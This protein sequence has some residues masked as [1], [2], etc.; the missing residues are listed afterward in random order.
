MVG[1]AVAGAHVD[2]AAPATG[3][4]APGPPSRRDALVEDEVLHCG[5]FADVA[6]RFPTTSGD[7][8]EVYGQRALFALLSP[9]LR[10]QLFPAAEAACRSGGRHEVQLDP[11][12]TARGFQ[13]VVRYVYRLPPQFTRPAL[14]EIL[15]AAHVLDVRELEE[16]AFTWGLAGLAERVQTDVAVDEACKCVQGA[17]D[18]NDCVAGG[19]YGDEVTDALWCLEQLCTLEPRAKRVTAWR[20]ALIK[21]YT[22]KQILASEAFFGLSPVTLEELLKEDS[23]HSDPGT[24]WVT[25]VH[26]AWACAQRHPPVEQPAMPEGAKPPKLFGRNT[27][28]AAILAPAV[29]PGQLVAWQ[30]QLLPVVE[31]MRFAQMAAA[32]FAKHVESLDPMLPELRQA[33]FS[34]RRRAATAQHQASVPPQAS[35]QPPKHVAFA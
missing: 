6:F 8:E 5:Y 28:L 33:I 3:P 20:E 19:A 2:A 7:V 21:A 9:V 12:I 16:A 13:E 25:C 15:V 17:P 34:T 32:E 10:E 29:P 26:W 23:M 22:T 4:T 30:Q 35:T 31:H 27:R 1:Q 11:A 14:P 24:L 18:R